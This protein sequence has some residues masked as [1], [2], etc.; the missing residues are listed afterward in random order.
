MA[1]KVTVGVQ[2]E[3]KGETQPPAHPAYPF[4]I[5][6]QTT[7]RHAE[8]ANVRAV[9]LYLIPSSSPGIG[10]RK[11]KVYNRVWTV[12]NKKVNIISIKL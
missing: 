5:H 3:S 4:V 7:C 10:R 2:K 9:A 1:S 11:G 8:P 12:V 6:E